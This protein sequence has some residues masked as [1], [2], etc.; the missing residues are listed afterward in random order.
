MATLTYQYK[1][2]EYENVAKSQTS[3]KMDT[4]GLTNKLINKLR[5]ASG[6]AIVDLISLIL[7]CR[8]AGP[9]S[10][11]VEVTTRLSSLKGDLHRLQNMECDLDE[12]RVRLQSSLKSIAE[13]TI[14]DQYAYITHEDICRIPSFQGETI[15]AIQAP[16]GT[17][18][19]V[20]LM[21]PQNGVS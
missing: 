4:Q 12:Q 8:G 15:L 16:S 11:S 9:S 1:T 2:S 7:C 5:L 3:L 19:E 13:D 21:P 6:C 10:N 20:P 14:N 18:L 17:E